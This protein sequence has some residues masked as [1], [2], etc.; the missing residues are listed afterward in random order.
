MGIV[1]PSDSSTFLRKRADR[2]GDSG[3]AQ[4]QK[5]TPFDRFD[6]LWFR[7]A[8]KQKTRAM[9]NSKSHRV[10][11]ALLTLTVCGV[12]T[13]LVWLPTRSRQVEQASADD[14]KTKSARADLEALHQKYARV[15]SVHLIATAQISIYEDR[16]RE[17]TGSFEYW[18]ENNRYRTSCR[19]DPQLELLSDIDMGYDG[20]RFYYLDRKTGML[21]YRMQDEE[22]SFGALPNPFFLPMD[23][24]SNDTDEC[25]F[26]RL[27][28]KDFHSRTTHWDKQKDRISVRSKGKEQATQ[29]D[30]TELE[31]PGEV[32]DKKDSK[33]RL[34]LTANANGIT[35][36]TKIERLQPDDRPLTS[37]TV[38]DFISTAAG[39]FPRH[40]QVQAFDSQSTVIMKVDY[41][42]DTLEVN[43]PIDQS[44]FKIK[45]EEAEGVWDSDA[46]KVI[47]EKPIKKK[48]Q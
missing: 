34:H 20:G 35:H 18:A 25:A 24:F 39:D 37:I 27:R 13:L 4:A 7:G 22:K 16:V 41:F 26:C 43:Q 38:S 48:P 45:D 21:S 11:L 23:F 42:I 3:C 5:R 36:A 2:R 1:V 33:F 30:F 8:Q 46:K 6:S 12:I 9:T 32:I 19:T 31:I 15:R 40:I 28:L 29:L 44:V 10:F 47:K 14:E 17:G